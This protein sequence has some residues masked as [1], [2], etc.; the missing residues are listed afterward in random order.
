MR[1]DDGRDVDLAEFRFGRREVPRL[2]QLPSALDAA[3]RDVFF[4]R[5][6]VDAWRAR[7]IFAL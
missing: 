1:G 4:Y 2:Q 3:R 7:A 5:H 6:F